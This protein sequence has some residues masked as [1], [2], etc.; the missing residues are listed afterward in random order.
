MMKN[1]KSPTLAELQRQP[2]KE[3]VHCQKCGLLIQETSY[4]RMCKR[5]GYAFPECFMPREV[6]AFPKLCFKH[7]EE[8]DVNHRRIVSFVSYLLLLIFLIPCLLISWLFF[9]WLGAITH[10]LYLCLQHRWC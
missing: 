6:M 10:V 8:A 9:E 4:Q 7:E 3:H 5:M 1:I 2:L